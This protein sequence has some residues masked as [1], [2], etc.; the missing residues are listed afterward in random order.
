[1]GDVRIVLRGNND[2][3]SHNSMRQK[4]FH[5]GLGRVADEVRRRQKWG[6]IGLEEPTLKWPD[7]EDAWGD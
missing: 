4:G 3:K 1:M 6:E 7:L 5:I 2:G